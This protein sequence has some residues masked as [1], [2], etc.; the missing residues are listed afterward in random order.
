MITPEE[1]QACRVSAFRRL[2][3]NIARIA[4]S[5]LGPLV[6]ADILE[7]EAKRLRTAEVEP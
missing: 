4:L 2:V 3:G 7:A 1:M 5:Q 6:I